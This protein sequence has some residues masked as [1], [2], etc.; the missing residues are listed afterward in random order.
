MRKTYLIGLVI[1]LAFWLGIILYSI[2]ELFNR[3]INGGDIFPVLTTIF[4]IA[5]INRLNMMENSFK[6]ILEWLNR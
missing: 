5:I 6:R 4:C 2:Y 1:G 3:I